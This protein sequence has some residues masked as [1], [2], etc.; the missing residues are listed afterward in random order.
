M[1]DPSCDLLSRKDAHSAFTSAFQLQLPCCARAAYWGLLAVECFLNVFSLFLVFLLC[2]FLLLLFF[3]GQ[4]GR[5]LHLFYVQWNLNP[6]LSRMRKNHFLKTQISCIANT[7]KWKKS[8]CFAKTP[9][10]GFRLPTASC[11]LVSRQRLTLIKDLKEHNELE[12]G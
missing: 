6:I 7:S 12:G 4:K 5:I 9:R 2:F 10:R 1:A 3:F 11:C 8:Q